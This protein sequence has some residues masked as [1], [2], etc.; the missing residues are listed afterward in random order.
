MVWR[1]L[2]VLQ[3]GLKP[4]LRKLSQNAQ[5]EIDL[6]GQSKIRVPDEKIGSVLRPSAPQRFF[7]AKVCVKRIDQLMGRARTC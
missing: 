3:S 4:N 1:F 6:F 5:P 2:C 7:A